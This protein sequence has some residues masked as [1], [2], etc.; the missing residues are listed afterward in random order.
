MTICHSFV[1]CDKSWPTKGPEN[2]KSCDNDNCAVECDLFFVLFPRE[3]YCVCSDL[4]VS[5]SGMHNLLKIRN[6]FCI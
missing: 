4:S 5:L 2:Y 1:S 6:K 3:G